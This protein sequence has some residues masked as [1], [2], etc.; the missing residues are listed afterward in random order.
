[1]IFSTAKQELIRKEFNHL[2]T[3]YFNTAYFG[4]TPY[5]AK[6]KLSNALFKEL[7]PS[8]FPF[9]SWMGIPDRIRSKIA[10]LLKVFPNQLA[11]G[12]STSDFMSM[13]ANHYPIGSAGI[14]VVTL[15]GEYPS[16]VLPWMVAREY[17]KGIHLHFLDAPEKSGD[18]LNVAWLEKNLPANANVVCLSHVQ[19]DT[20]RCFNLRESV[21]VSHLSNNI[22]IILEECT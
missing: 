16:S 20:G 6:Q 5:R 21:E 12:T 7:D 2:S 11:L 3:N 17:R 4:P 15:N 14:H 9:H 1:M 22:C 8:F 18:L 13:I 10:H 19:F